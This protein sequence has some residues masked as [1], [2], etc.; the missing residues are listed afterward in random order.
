[1]TAKPGVE[2]PVLTTRFFHHPLHIHQ[3]SL[4]SGIVAASSESGAT[5]DSD[6]KYMCPFYGHAKQKRHRSFYPSPLDNQPPVEEESIGCVLGP[7]SNHVGNETL[8]KH[9]DSAKCKN[10]EG[11]C[12]F[13]VASVLCM[14]HMDYSINPTVSTTA[15]TITLDMAIGCL[16]DFYNIDDV[17]EQ[18]VKAAMSGWKNL[19]KFGFLKGILTHHNEYIDEVYSL[20]WSASFPQPGSNEET[21]YLNLLYDRYIRPFKQ[22]RRNGSSRTSTPRSSAPPSVSS[23]SAADLQKLEHADFK[24]ALH[25][26]DKVCLF[27]WGNLQLDAAHVIAQ[28]SSIALIIAELLARSSLNSVYEVQNGVLLCKVCHGE[29]DGLRRYIDV[30]ENDSLVAKVVNLT[31]DPNNEDYVDALDIVKAIRGTKAKRFHGRNVVNGNGE[32]QIYFVQNDPAIYPN[33]IALE[34]HKTACLI[35]KM[36]GG[37]DAELDEEMEV[38]D[39]DIG[40][41]AGEKFMIIQ[42]WRESVGTL[43]N[44]E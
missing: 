5:A 2:A 26:R 7:W 17:N 24:A 41:V 8:R 34:F 4:E 39:D 42:A 16:K 23:S 43:N 36:A 14:K 38:D 13:V 37:A 28:K 22:H 25:S 1:M 18:P 27:C 29:F 40:V 12:R 33:R 10:A 32:M 6:R 9:L 11:G 20:L 30:D 35:W 15:P 19:N 31:N 21:D 3:S 44:D